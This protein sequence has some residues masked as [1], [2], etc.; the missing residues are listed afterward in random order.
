MSK[1]REEDIKIHSPTAGESNVTGYHETKASIMNR[2][3]DGKAKEVSKLDTMKRSHGNRVGGTLAGHNYID[4]N[5]GAMNHQ[6]NRALEDIEALRERRLVYPFR[7]GVHS[8][9]LNFSSG[10]S[11]KGSYMERKADPAQGRAI[12]GVDTAFNRL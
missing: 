11:T 5:R 4:T 6:Q 7:G 10:R 9:F 3:S 12:V 2:L 1:I 8:P